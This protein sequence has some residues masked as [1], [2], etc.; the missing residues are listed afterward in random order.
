[1][2]T[3]RLQDMIVSEHVGWKIIST[4]AMILAKYNA[5]N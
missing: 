3:S 5:V 2:D 1:M 4:T